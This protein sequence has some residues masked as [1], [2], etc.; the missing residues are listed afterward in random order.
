MHEVWLQSSDLSL[1]GSLYIFGSNS[2]KHID[3]GY[4]VNAIPPTALSGSFWN[5]TG[6]LSIS[7]DVHCV[8]LYSSDYFCHFIAV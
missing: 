5:F 1:F 7:E 3:T 8:R 2:P 6:V 4:L